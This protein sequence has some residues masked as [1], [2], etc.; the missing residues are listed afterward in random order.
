M[1]RYMKIRKYE[2][3]LMYRDKEFRKV[4]RPGRHVISNPLFR[5]NVEVV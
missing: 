2:R 3:G 1:I 5:V 4:L